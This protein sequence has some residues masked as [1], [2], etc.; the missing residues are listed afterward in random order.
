MFKTFFN[1]LTPETRKK[2]AANSGTTLG[3]IEKHFLSPDPLKRKVPR[4]EL[5]AKMVDASAGEL[6]YK[7]LADYFYIEKSRAYKNKAA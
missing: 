4:P 7:E 1:K 6:N 3:Y 5:M 2:F